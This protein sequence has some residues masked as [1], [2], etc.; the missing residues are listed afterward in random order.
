MGS[1]IQLDKNSCCCGVSHMLSWSLYI[2]HR[3]HF[4][5][6]I[7]DSDCANSECNK[8]GSCLMLRLDVVQR[9]DCDGRG[10][11]HCG[12]FGRSSLEFLQEEN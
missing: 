12:C 5:Q 6:G 9:K 7:E 2:V 3:G 8:D 11:G 10:W 4:H 1:R